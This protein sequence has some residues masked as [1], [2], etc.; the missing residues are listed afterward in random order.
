MVLI[1]N[2]NCVS[3]INRD[4]FASTLT[5]VAALVIL[6]NAWHCLGADIPRAETIASPA[7]LKTQTTNSERT[8]YESRSRWKTILWL[9][10]IHNC[11]GSPRNEHNPTSPQPCCDRPNKDSTMTLAKSLK[12]DAPKIRLRFKDATFALPTI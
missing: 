4:K 3:A 8:A 2:Y 12:V 7:L 1:E 5:Y 10:A 11:A 9:H 6:D